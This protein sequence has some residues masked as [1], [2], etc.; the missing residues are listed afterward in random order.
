MNGHNLHCLV[1]ALKN[2]YLH[3]RQHG[4][5]AKTFL[6]A[7]FPAANKW[8][9]VTNEDISMALKTATTI[10]DYPTAKG[11][12]IKGIDMHS[13]RSGGANTLSLAGF[14]DTQIQKMGRWHGATF[15][16]YIREELAFF[17]EGIS[18]QMKQKFHFVNVTGNSFN[19]ITDDLVATN[20]TVIATVE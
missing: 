9:D 17:S 14:S 7:Y 18:K 15:K 5:T 20:Y 8:A 6:S 11:I 4:A 16:E 10:L 1:Q 12:P 2:C 3:L 19:N 13:L